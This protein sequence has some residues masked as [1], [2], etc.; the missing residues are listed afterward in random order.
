M[1]QILTFSD[2][3][4]DE[5]PYGAIRWRADTDKIGRETTTP[6]GSDV[7]A[8]LDE[9]VA[10]RPGAGSAPLFPA[11]GDPTK[12]IDKYLADKLRKR[13]IALA[14][15]EARKQGRVLEFP[16]RWGFHSFRRK[17]ATEL[18]RAPDRD[19]ADLGGWKDLNTLREIYQMADHDTMVA[20][21][22]SRLE[23]REAK[24]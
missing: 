16:P 11:P 23:L 15:Q 12:A 2:L 6:I 24:G 5:K 20:A 14:K 3:R 22:A 13:G 9:I 10:M 8:V 7:R 18:K 19:V 4:L 21:L 17:F 1:S